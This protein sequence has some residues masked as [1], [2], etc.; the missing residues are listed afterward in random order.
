MEW[1]LAGRENKSARKSDGNEA[2]EMILAFK[3]DMT[4]DY[5]GWFSNMGN[6]ES[7]ESE[8]EDEEKQVNTTKEARQVNKMH[9]YSSFMTTSMNQ[10]QGLTIQWADTVEP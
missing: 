1:I 6:F 3:R 9:Y 5:E 4:D 2:F 10:K 7:S 8:C